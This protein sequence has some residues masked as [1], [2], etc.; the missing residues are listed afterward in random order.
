MLSQV[1]LQVLVRAE[2]LCTVFKGAPKDLWLLCGGETMHLSRILVSNGS[3]SLRALAILT[4]KALG[5]GA[6]GLNTC[7]QGVTVKGCFE[8]RRLGLPVGGL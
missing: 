7:G 4:F 6:L 5:R 1:C 3:H 8:H 2:F